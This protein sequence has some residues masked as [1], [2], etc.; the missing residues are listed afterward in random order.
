[1]DRRDIFSLDH[2]YSPNYLSW[3]ATHKQFSFPNALQGLR[4]ASMND[5]ET[6]KLEGRVRKVLAEYGGE[7]AAKDVFFRGIG[8]GFSGSRVFEVITPTVQRFFLKQWPI[9][10]PSFSRLSAIH[11]VLR[12]IEDRDSSRSLPIPM[13]AAPVRNRL[14]QTITIADTRLWE[15]TPI[16]PGHPVGP[17]EVTADLVE[18]AMQSIA[19]VH[20]ALNHV[21]GN[22]LSDFPVSGVPGPSP[23][24]ANRKSRI[25]SILRNR[26][27]WIGVVWPDSLPNQIRNKCQSLLDLAMPE[28][29][30]LSSRN[31]WERIPLPLQL[32]ICDL[33]YAHLFFSDSQVSGIIDFGSIQVDCV[34][35]D[36]ARLLRSWF[37]AND[38]GF[39]SALDAYCKVRP[40]TCNERQAFPWFDRTSRVLSAFQWIEWLAIERREFADWDAVS[41][42][43]DFV[44]ARLPSVGI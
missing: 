13:L 16:V 1:L 12:S 37:A 28:V 23:R 24:L 21:G 30:S 19:A 32:T 40:L 9:S 35:T 26:S 18:S 43:L 41:D 39:E 36:L 3:E 7:I 42:R 17:D 27:A 8:G 29:E 15:L 10:G 2:K 38:A 5:L 44:Q 25:D 14:G 22:Q 33:W 6:A 20:L 34:V 31:G 4:L 11:Q